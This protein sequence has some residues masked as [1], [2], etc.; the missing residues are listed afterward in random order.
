MDHN[1][2]SSTINYRF[3]LV[4]FSLC[5]LLYALYASS[6]SLGLSQDGAAYLLRIIEAKNFVLQEP[7]RPASH[8]LQQWAV[9]MLLRLGV[10]KFPIL[11]FTYTFC[12]IAT[13]AL[14]I[15]I[16]FAA[17]PERHK[18]AFI[19]P[20]L[21]FL[22]GILSSL[23]FP[24]GE[25]MMAG[26]YFW[27]IFM[28][29]CYLPYTL[30]SVCILTAIS[31]PGPWMHEGMIFLLPI[32]AVAASIR[33]RRALTSAERAFFIC[34]SFAYLALIAIPLSAFFH[35]VKDFERGRFFRNTV[36]FRFLVWDDQWNVPLLLAVFAI[37]L[38][39]CNAWLIL[40][41]KVAAARYRAWLPV[42]LT[43][44]GVV[45]VV[46]TVASDRLIGVNPIKEARNVGAFASAGFACLFLLVGQRKQFRRLALDPCTIRLIGALILVQYGWY[47]VATMR[48]AEYVRDLQQIV[49]TCRGYVPFDVALGVLPNRH[50]N[51]FSRMSAGW[52]NPA[53]SVLLAPAQTV[54]AIVGSRPVRVEPIEI[55][56]PLRRESLPA[57]ALL[58]YAPYEATLGGQATQGPATCPQP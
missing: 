39:G 17:L 14:F 7:G 24:I 5:S 34:L 58:D 50:A 31:L 56:D 42:A 48:W 36:R 55:F 6:C 46:S 49:T 32:L 40:R 57:S 33:A 16:S 2:S 37:A 53:L 3:I 44:I 52:T 38:I 19:F 28:C 51:L 18:S 23:Y 30:S 12:M 25:A 20:I 10:T 21:S 26:S 29:I 1:W 41:A 4:V 11:I 43:G 54:M 15:I 27:L 45:V 8:V 47:T 22:S 13:P 35:P 9:V